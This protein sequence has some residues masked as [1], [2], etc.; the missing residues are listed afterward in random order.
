MQQPQ[1]RPSSGRISLVYGVIFG[2]II[3]GIDLVYSLILD[4]TNP[5]F[6]NSLFQGFAALKLDTTLAN[7]LYSLVLSSP[8]YI[9]L[10]VSF[11]LVGLFA[12]RKTNKVSTGVLAALWTGVIFMVVD[13]IIVNILLLFVFTFPTLSTSGTSSAEVA[14]LESSLLTFS[15]IFSIVAGVISMGIGLG[16]GALGGL[17]GRGQGAAPVQPYQVPVYANPAQFPYSPMPAPG[18]ASPPFPR[19]EE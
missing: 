1:A 3:G 7:V 6:L 19:A 17:M 11:L 4:L 12:S 9:L 18:P 10:L 15:V 2:L 8:V 13:L 14:N 16:L 5:P